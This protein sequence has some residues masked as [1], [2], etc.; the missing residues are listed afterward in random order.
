MFEKI[1]E[2]EI[3]DG[4]SDHGFWFFYECQQRR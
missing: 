2:E 1:N 3:C 4:M